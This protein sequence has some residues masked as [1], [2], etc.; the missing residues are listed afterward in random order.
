MILGQNTAHFRIFEEIDRAMT[1]LLHEQQDDRVVYFNPH[2]DSPIPT[3]SIVY[4]L[5]NVGI[6]LAPTSFSTDRQIWDFSARNV[7][8][9]HAAGR[10]A[11]H[12]PIGF[13]RSMECFTPRPYEERDIDVVLAG[14][15]NPRRAALVHQLRAEGLHV[16][17]L[18]GR[19]GKQRDDVLARAKLAVNPL[20]Y[21]DGVFPILR[22]AHAAANRLPIISEIAPEAPTWV[23]PAPVAYASLVTTLCAAL[24][25]GH[26]QI[27]TIAEQAYATFA[28]HPLLL[29]NRRP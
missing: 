1:A 10:D 24:S 19:Y 9:W 14:S 13:H 25:A 17:T 23:L 27:D 7:E 3:R 15:M 6:Q 12:V 2:I 16:A 29:P 11:T 21:E 28:A 26:V 20:F 8:R 5:E 4:N 18:F 22:Y